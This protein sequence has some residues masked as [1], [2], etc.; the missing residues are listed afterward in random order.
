MLEAFAIVKYYGSSL[1]PA[2][3]GVA[4][5]SLNQA[6][7][8]HMDKTPHRAADDLVPDHALP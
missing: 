2:G 4:G 5:E 1:A 7:D 3:T 8:D 6:H